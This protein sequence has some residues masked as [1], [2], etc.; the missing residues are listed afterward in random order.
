MVTWKKRTDAN[1]AKIVGDLR[2]I[3]GYSVATGYDDI[4]VGFNGITLW[5]EVKNANKISKKTKE[6]L[7]SAKRDSQIRLDDTFTGARIYVTKASDVTDWYSKNT[8]QNE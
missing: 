6:L 5:C 2:K 8:Q 7:E 4:I 1:Q 3:Q